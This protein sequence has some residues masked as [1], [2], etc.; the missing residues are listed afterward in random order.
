MWISYRNGAD[1]LYINFKKPSHATG[2]EL[3]HED[4]I[5]RY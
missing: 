3:T 1:M 5:I 4:V 2:S